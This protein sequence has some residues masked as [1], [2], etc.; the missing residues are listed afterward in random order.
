M[1]S[2]LSILL[3]LV[4]TFMA[5]HP[6]H[7]AVHYAV[8]HLFLVGGAARDVTS[9]LCHQATPPAL[10][11]G[12]NWRHDSDDMVIQLCQQRQRVEEI[13]PSQLVF[14]HIAVYDAPVCP[15]AMELF[16]VVHDDRVVCVRRVLA[17]EVLTSGNYISDVWVSTQL[18]Y[19][20]DAVG[21]RTIP[22]S[23]QVPAESLLRSFW[24]S[25][26]QSSYHGAFISYQRPV[27]PVREVR[28]LPDANADFLKTAC[29]T[30]FS[31]HWEDTGAGYLGHGS[32]NKGELCMRRA[33]DSEN[34]PVLLEVAVTRGASGCSSRFSQTETLDHG[35]HLCFRWGEA[36]A[37]EAPIVGIFLESL[38]VG[39]TPQ[40]TL[41]G[42]YLLVSSTSLNIGHRAVFIYVSRGLIKD[43]PYS[44]PL[45]R[46]PLVAKKVAENDVT[47]KLTFKILQ[48]ADLHYTGD[49]T[50][51]CKDAPSEIGSKA[52]SEAIM[53]KF[54]NELL[55][56]E[57]PDFVAFSGDNVETFKSSLRQEAMDAAT[58]GVE[59]RGIPHSMI[60]GN[61]DDVHGFSRESLME[62][63][64]KKKHSYTQRGP[65]GVYGVG[66]YEL[67]VQAPV[68]GLWGVA[69][70]DVFRMYFLDSNA[71]PVHGWLRSEDT[72][73]DWI[74]PNQVEY[75]RQMS[76]AHDDNR[77]PAIMFFH[78]PL[79]EYGMDVA[80]QRTGQ[81]REDV[82]SSEVHSDLFSTLVELDEV[83]A[84]FAGHDHVNEYCY[85]RESVQLCYGGGAGF[86]VAYGMKEVQRRAR[87]IEWSVNTENKREIRTW[88]RVFGRLDERL[89]DQ[90]LYSN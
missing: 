49:P 39:K 17:S 63:A 80:D 27:V 48:L 18:H 26:W 22:E 7:A 30:W 87:V 65:L 5:S 82:L 58:A 28:I 53:T 2:F 38:L 76:A 13:D 70:S 69:G 41:P 16:F 25:I 77:V 60:F 67:N 89:D 34:T 83:K 20:T 15:T 79:P 11:V 71:Y 78:I 90:L 62:M 33:F 45:N 3:L 40:P 52:C 29:V 42:G 84:T 68:D 6:A 59:A 44:E 61:H 8:T 4:A 64:M 55:D 50:T 88:K 12:V 74:R 66:N 23:V 43:L 86:G 19:N 46:P 35:V 72:K 9:E 54:V 24:N 10:A 21:W 51:E 57:K 81:H 1:R 85:K 31:A 37:T 14:Q 75:Y 32:H 36:T 56:F 47:T 73:Y